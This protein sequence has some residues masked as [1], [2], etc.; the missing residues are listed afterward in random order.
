MVTRALHVTLF[1]MSLASAIFLCLFQC[2]FSKAFPQCVEPP[3]PLSL[4]PHGSDCTALV[5]EI[6]ATSMMQS[7]EPIFWSRYRLPPEQMIRSRLLPTILAGPLPNNNCQ[8]VVDV[9]SQD[10]SDV[11]P[12]SWISD[13]ARQ[14]VEE[15]LLVRQT[16]GSH[17][18]WPR[19]IVEIT[20]LRKGSNDNSHILDEDGHNIH[21]NGTGR[22]PTPASNHSNS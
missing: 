7:N 20:L 18:V 17:Y 3:P 9:T 8:F 14:I 6:L 16:L 15:C 21:L 10:G 12:L 22:M 5:E 2:L 13:A 1:T 19:G 4:I 11:F